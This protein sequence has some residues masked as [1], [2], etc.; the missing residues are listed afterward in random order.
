MELNEN[1]AYK[2]KSMEERISI[3]E[4]IYNHDPGLISIRTTY[5]DRFSIRSYYNYPILKLN[6]HNI[7]CG[8]SELTSYSHEIPKED[9]LDKLLGFNDCK[10]GIKYRTIKHKFI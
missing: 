5:D 10:N 2:T 9:F 4:M 8:W 3:I 1:E 6:H 7:I